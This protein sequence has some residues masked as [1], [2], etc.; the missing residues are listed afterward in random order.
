MLREEE[1]VSIV[2]SI[3]CTPH[4]WELW[5][6]MAE[7]SGLSRNRWIRIALADAAAAVLAER[8]ERDS[9]RASREFLR[10]LAF[11]QEPRGS[12]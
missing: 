11:P 2:K 12:G 9:M 7:F 1:M 10:K 8:K 6:Q 4:E 5:G 3:R